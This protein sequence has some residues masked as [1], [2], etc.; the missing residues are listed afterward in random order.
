[1][2]FIDTTPLDPQTLK[3]LYEFRARSGEDWKEKLLTAWMSASEPG[4]LQRLRNER[5]P[6]WLAQYELPEGTPDAPRRKLTVVESS[7]LLKKTLRASFP[8]TKFSVRMSRGTGYGTL[9]VSWSGPSADDVSK[10]TDS[11]E[12]WQ[13]DGVDDSTR[14]KPTALMLASGE[15]VRSGA[16]YV[17]LMRDNDAQE[18]L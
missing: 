7:K 13:F 9:Y 6:S 2:I 1:M 11:F 10:V 16:K 5:G 12:G 3:S 18:A 4:L 8:G 17:L 15:I 14:I